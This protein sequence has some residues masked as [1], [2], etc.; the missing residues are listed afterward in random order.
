MEKS[1]IKFSRTARDISGSLYF[2]VPKEV[3]EYLGIKPGE[4]ITIVAL[5]GKHGR[6]GAFWKKEVIKEEQDGTKK[7]HA[8]VED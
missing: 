8:D 2:A 7:I 1:A 3:A 6:Y 4:E 5:E